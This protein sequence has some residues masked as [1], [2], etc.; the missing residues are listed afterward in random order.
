MSYSRIGIC[1][2]QIV[3][4]KLLE[5]AEFVDPFAFQAKNMH[6]YAPRKARAPETLTRKITL[7]QVEVPANKTAYKGT[8]VH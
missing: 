3:C 1:R 8:H 2:A 5:P 6:A 4:V 7:L